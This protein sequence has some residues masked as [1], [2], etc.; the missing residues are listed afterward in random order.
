MGNCDIPG[1]AAASSKEGRSDWWRGRKVLRRPQGREEK[2]DLIYCRRKRSK[3]DPGKRFYERY[4][5]PGLL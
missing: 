5:Q 3:K 2:A 1:R 4:D